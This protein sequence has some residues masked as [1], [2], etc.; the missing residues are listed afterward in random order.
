MKPMCQK[1]PAARALEETVAKSQARESARIQ[2]ECFGSS[3]PYA[4]AMSTETK[5][6]RMTLEQWAERIGWSYED[7]DGR[8]KALYAGDN[9][10]PCEATQAFEAMAEAAEEEI[11]N[12]E[13]EIA[14]LNVLIEDLEDENEMWSRRA[15]AW[16]G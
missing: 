9:P 5:K 4:E 1:S 12:A 3:K 13:E 8:G 15:K 2:H 6:K 11:A 16:P 7:R 10:L 14:K